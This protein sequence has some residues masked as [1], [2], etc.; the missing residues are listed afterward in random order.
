M[1]RSEKLVRY[2]QIHKSSMVVKVSLSVENLC[3]AGIV[4]RYVV[5]FDLYTTLLI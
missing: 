1:A 2:H 4:T 5:L 3:R